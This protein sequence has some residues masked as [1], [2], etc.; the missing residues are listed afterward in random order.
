MSSLS[1]CLFLV[2][3]PLAVACSSADDP[4]QPGGDTDAG[5]AS[6]SSGEPTASSSSSSS[7]SSSGSSALDSGPPDAA[8]GAGAVQPIDPIVV[9]NSWTYD[10]TELGVYPLCPD[11]SHT[12]SV[13]GAR[14]LDGKTALTVES[15][16]EDLGPYDY[17][18]EG[19][20]VFTYDTVA[21][22]WTLALDA[23]VEAGHA[24]TA[25][26]HDFTWKAQAAVTVPA[27]TFEDCWSATEV[28]EYDSYTV[29]CRGVGPV[30]W[31]YEDGF[32]NGYDAL[33]T[34]K[35]F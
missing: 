28:A 18:V 3:L 6:S 5:A 8:D 7:G 30:H 12:S 17:A 34:A 15:L 4:A 25:S 16:C 10:V 27:G 9:G 23:P 31:H 35:S 29:F 11:G 20:R 1:F 2:A 33:M 21:S 24:W 13:T 22:E 19:D 14:D 32:G 26:D